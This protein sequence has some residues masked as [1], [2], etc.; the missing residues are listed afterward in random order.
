MVYFQQQR[1]K[2]FKIDIAG[3]MLKICNIAL[4][5]E[6]TGCITLGGGAAKHFT[7][8]AQIFR[9]GCDYAVY[10]NTAQE[11]D[12]SDSG[13]RPDEAVSWGKIKT[14]GKAVKVHCDATIAFPLLVA[15]TFAN[16]E[17]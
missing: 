1:N 7:L 10:I 11:F 2:E 4:R 17:R 6:K 9:D 5:S 16:K 15:A 8:N 13:A 12:G 3:D 14:D